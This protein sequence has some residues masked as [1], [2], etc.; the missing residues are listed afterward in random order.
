MPE[1]YR[2]LVELTQVIDGAPYSERW[3]VIHTS[4]P[5]LDWQGSSTKLRARGSGRC[6]NST[7]S[8]SSVTSIRWSR[9]TLGAESRVGVRV[10]ERE[11]ASDGRSE[12]MTDRELEA[13]KARVVHRV[14]VDT[15]DD[16]YIAARWC[17]FNAL[18]IDFH[19]LGV[20]A[21]EKYLKATLLLNGKSA[22]GFRHDIVKLYRTVSTIAGD[23]LPKRLDQPKDL[24]TKGW[25]DEPAE[26]FL[27]RLHDN[28]EA[29]NRYDLFGFVQMHHD[30]F[31]LD[32]VVFA[33]RRLCCP[34]DQPFWPGKPEK[35]TNRMALV[36]EPAWW[37][38]RS[39]GH[40]ERTLHGKRGDELRTALL[41]LNTRIAPEDSEHGVVRTGMSASNSILGKEIVKPLQGP[42]GRAKDT[43]RDLRA[44]VIDNIY[45]PKDVIQELLDAEP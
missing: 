2:P 10:R 26:Q 7:R 32:H 28:G 4:E 5:F 43:A 14:F 31:K 41:D 29:N 17:Y 21:L 25:R 22:R 1:G 38:L 40:L 33:V 15:A 3:L 35:G 8:T 36:A 34:L 20:H 39:D 23:L 45:L 37:S 24:N 19:W 11:S 16:N 6:S 18:R 12:A 30:L 42:A 27:K 13:A 44:W 9:A